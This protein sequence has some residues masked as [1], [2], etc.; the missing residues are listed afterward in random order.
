MSLIRGHQENCPA[1]L[2]FNPNDVEKFAGRQELMDSIQV[3]VIFPAFEFFASS[4][5]A[6]LKAGATR[7]ATPNRQD[8]KV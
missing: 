7:T 6:R 4:S 8:L 1:Y 2:L 5:R 3:T